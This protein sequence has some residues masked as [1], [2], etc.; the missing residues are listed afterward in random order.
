[1][2]FII[3]GPAV[4]NPGRTNDT[5]VGAVD[6][7]STILEMA[8]INVA[9]TT[10]NLTL[11]SQSLLPLLTNSTTLSRYAY[12]ELFGSAVA[13]N[14]AG[15][16]LRNGQFK[17]I[18]FTNGQQA[19]YDL[20]NDPYEGTNLLSGALNATQQ[21]HYY[22]LT[23][24]MGGYQNTLIAPVI[25]GSSFSNLQFALTVQRTT[26]MSYTLWRA[27]VLDDLAWV[28]LTNAVVVT[29]SSTVV[30][31]TDVTSTNATS[32]YRV[33]GSSP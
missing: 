23:L 10:A 26:N 24:K 30:T 18:Q 28:P 13:V 11:D 20:L 9:A 19:L 17:L 15:R 29:N 3:A 25:T 14:S 6:V 22:S 27:P 1:M 4:T 21:A 7:F 5:P 12:A 31:L 16:A 8:G 33:V 32:F 2:P